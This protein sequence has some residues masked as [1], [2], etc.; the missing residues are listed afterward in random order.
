MTTPSTEASLRVVFDLLLQDMTLTPVEP[1]A[2]P[3]QRPIFVLR[4]AHM[5]RMEAFFTEVASRAPSPELHVMSHARD[6]AALRAAA[7][8]PI[9]FHPYETEG[10]YR[11][12]DVAAATLARLRQFD[13]GMLFFLDAGTS[14][15]RMLDVEELVCAAGTAR[16]VTFRGDDTFVTSGNWQQR[17]RAMQAFLRLVA[18]YQVSAGLEPPA[19]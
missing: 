13:F 9:I 10:P 1:A 12:A 8:F 15:D 5:G 14:G 6:E 2:L 7:P 4:S 18:W 11:L 19:F 16:V 17:G 3:W